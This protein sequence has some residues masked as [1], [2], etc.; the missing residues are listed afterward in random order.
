MAIVDNLSN[1]MDVET[2]ITTK[3]ITDPITIEFLRKIAESKRLKTQPTT[4]ICSK[5]IIP[6][7]LKQPSLNSHQEVIK[8]A[9]SI[10]SMEDIKETNPTN[11][12]IMAPPHS[13]PTNMAASSINTNLELQSSPKI[14]YFVNLPSDNDKSDDEFDQFAISY[15]SN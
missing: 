2:I 5:A 7:S 4:M 9:S 11:S 10:S 14:N 3:N 6:T 8:V 1:G 12:T 13:L 15:P